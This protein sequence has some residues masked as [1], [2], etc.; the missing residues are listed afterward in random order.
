ML[1]QFFVLSHGLTSLF[2]YQYHRYY[3]I[4]KKISQNGG[5]LLNS[6]IFDFHRILIQI[7]TP[8]IQLLTTTR[9][10]KICQ[11]HDAEIPRAFQQQKECC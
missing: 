11:C 3:A 7:K 6:L 1:S 4:Y 8:S 5:L 9:K 2:N 10:T